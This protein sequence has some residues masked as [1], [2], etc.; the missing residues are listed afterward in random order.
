MAVK[1]RNILPV[2]GNKLYFIASDSPLSA[3]ICEL[4]SLKNISNTYVSSNYL[5]DDLIRARSEEISG[6]IDRETRKN[7]LDEPVACFWSQTFG[8]SRDLD[9][10]PLVI[11]MLGILFALP[12]I[13]VKRSEIIMYSSSLALAG[14]E[15]IALTVLQTSAGNMYQMTGLIMAGLMAGLATGA[16]SEIV[17]FERMDVRYKGLLL[18]VF[19]L[20]GAFA[21]GALT[22]AH[23]STPVIIVIIMM[24]SFVPALLTGSIFRSLTP[25]KTGITG[26]H[27]VYGADL[28]GSALGFILVSGLLIPLCG[29]KQAMWLSVI[30][31]FASLLVATLGNK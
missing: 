28:M 15:I 9:E 13:A 12:M 21:F 30:F 18:L 29:I 31:I 17:P 20:C 25:G 8:L 24:L 16:G 6:L 5:S 14:L 23:L 4:A 11:I 10:K 2:A 1:F 19:Y 27:S 22:G 3:S 7:T 26:V